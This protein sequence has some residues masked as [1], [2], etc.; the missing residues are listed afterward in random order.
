MIC[1]NLWFFVICFIFAFEFYTLSSGKTDIE[2]EHFPCLPNFW[3]N[4]SKQ[5][6]FSSYASL[7]LHILYLR[8][9]IYSLLQNF[10][11]DWNFPK[12]SYS[13]LALTT[14]DGWWLPKLLPIKLLLWWHLSVKTEK[15]A[16]IISGIIARKDRY[17]VKV[18]DTNECWKKLCNR[19]NIPFVDHII[20]ARAHINAHIINARAH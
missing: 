20:N 7:I 19:S 4:S 12:T 10:R 1:L 3:W 15:N 11:H 14:C 5:F 13:I 8:S 9:L 2:I 16:I 17:K 18:R 6:P